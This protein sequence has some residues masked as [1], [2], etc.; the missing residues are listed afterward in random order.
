[1]LGWILF[2]VCV[3]CVLLVFVR[4]LAQPWIDEHTR[5]ARIRDRIAGGEHPVMARA[6]EDGPRLFS[7]ARHRESVRRAWRESRC[8]A[9]GEAPEGVCILDSAHAG[10]HVFGSIE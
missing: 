10:P 9:S 6:A 1:M 7:E 3:V 5:A 2:V 4:K 8:G